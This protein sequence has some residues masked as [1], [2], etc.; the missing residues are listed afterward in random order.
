MDQ[1]TQAPEEL[2]L[3]DRAKQVLEL[4]TSSLS[5][6]KT[7]E[8]RDA[9]WAPLQDPSTLAMMV[10]A[11]GEDSGKLKSYIDVIGLMQGSAARSRSL[12]K[13]LVRLDKDSRVKDATDRLLQSLGTVAA[14]LTYLPP[15]KLVNPRI[16][17]ECLVPPGW[18]MD[19]SG[20]WRLSA[21][22]ESNVRVTT[23]PILLTGRSTDVL[24]G[25]AKR[26]VLWLGPAGWCQ[27]TVERL[28]LSESR[29]IVALAGLE[30][31]VNS[32]NAAQVVEFLSAYEAQNAAAL[33][34]ILS[35]EKLGWLP[36][37]AFVFPEQ[38]IVPAGVPTIPFTL[39]PPPGMEHL[40]AGMSVK[41]TWE[42]WLEAAEVAKDWPFLM[43]ALYASITPPLLHI[44]DASSFC[45]DLSG[46]TTGGKT[47][48]LRLAASAW[49][50]AHDGTG[51]MLH[52]WDMTK[53]WAEQTSNFYS[54][55][56]LILDDTKRAKSWGVV[57][58]VVYD[59]TFGAGRGRGARTGGTR[60]TTSW[61][62]VLLSS[63]EAA[64]T[65][66]SQDG[67]TRAR[68]LGLRGKPMGQNPMKG[69]KLAEQLSDILQDNYG[70]L[71]RRVVK[72]LT[73]CAEH[74]HLIKA[75]FN[76]SRDRYRALA[77][78]P[79]AKRH[80]G[81]IAAMEIASEI[82]HLCGLPRP[83]ES[84]FNYMVEA[85]NEAGRDADRPAAALS[86]VI[87]W[88]AAHQ[89]FFVGR[90]E[91]QGG[92]GYHQPV[93]GW[94][95]VWPATDWSYLGITGRVLRRVL[96]EEGFHFGEVLDRWVERGWIEVGEKTTRPLRGVNGSTLSCYCI[97]KEAVTAAMAEE[98]V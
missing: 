72:Y 43:L 31:P 95:G 75:Q 19:Q 20:V 36:D 68:V 50:K 82:A 32:G 38:R 83:A 52:S 9:A 1:D 51:S 91:R 18:A 85:A 84:P 53:V 93:V 8:E 5:T 17:A 62:S 47:T 65:S 59:F 3:L 48:A 69:S 92:G 63:G 97:T 4:L 40:A 58:D 81:N 57:R 14:S 60:S 76:Q 96:K 13:L 64:I 37:G 66:F 6:A 77:L 70:H 42:G 28:T 87:N 23:Y 73:S 61:Q 94:A 29:R 7:K 56:P 16:L 74:H 45:V 78:S 27:R 55:A 39:M 86:L 11:W 15:D 24:T 10:D 44:L 22:G 67:G 26:Q 25:M 30:A 46:E 12:V 88:A 89:T 71:A 90:A 80:A 21:D 2:T 54:H 34:L 41:G 79:V 33:P 49:G 98:M 35:T